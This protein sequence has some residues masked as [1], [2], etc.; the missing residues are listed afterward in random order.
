MTALT[1]NEA[2]A[3]AESVLRSL[4][5]KESLDDLKIVEGSVTETEEAWYFPYNS[6]RYLMYG[7]IS[8]ALAGNLPIK[9]PKNG[10]PVTYELPPGHC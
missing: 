3:E 5:E 9:V 2:R 10:S 1:K 8:A 7:D 6:V 4:A